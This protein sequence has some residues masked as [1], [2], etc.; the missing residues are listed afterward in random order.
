MERYDR[1]EEK[2]HQQPFE[3]AYLQIPVPEY[4][5]YSEERAQEEPIA[6]EER[7]VIIIDI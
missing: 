7:R 3:Y 6:P 5:P 2:P 4:P 1:R